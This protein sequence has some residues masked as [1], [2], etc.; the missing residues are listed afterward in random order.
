MT[1]SSAP[2]SSGCVSAGDRRSGQTFGEAARERSRFECAPREPFVPGMLREGAPDTHQRDSPHAERDDERPWKRAASRSHG[3]GDRDGAAQFVCCS[4]ERKRGHDDG[5]HRDEQPPC[6]LERLQC[7]G[8]H[9]LACEHD[10]AACQR[11]A[12]APLDEAKVAG[13]RRPAKDAPQREQPRHERN[14]DAEDDREPSERHE[15]AARRR[16]SGPRRR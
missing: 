7:G 2:V 5:R 3:R 15:Q 6:G 10:A 16:D 11:E 14:L 8:L 9:R 1:R 13:R 12:G 4:A